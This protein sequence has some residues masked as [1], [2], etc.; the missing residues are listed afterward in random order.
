MPDEIVPA[1]PLA[2]YEL[3]NASGVIVRSGALSE[4]EVVVDTE[5]LPAGIY[6]VRLEAQNGARKS[7][8]VSK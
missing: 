6:F 5:T 1:L 4:K 2:R 3:V 7:V 8:V